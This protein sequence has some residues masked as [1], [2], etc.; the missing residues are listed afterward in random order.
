MCIPVPRALCPKPGKCVKRNLSTYEKRRIYEKRPTKKA[1]VYLSLVLLARHRKGMWKE[2]YWCM[3]RDLYMKI[4]L[5]ERRIYSFLTCSLPD[6][7]K[8]YMNKKPFYAWKENYVRKDTF[9]KDVYVH[10]YIRIYKYLHIHIHIRT[11]IY[12][13]NVCVPAPRAYSHC[14]KHLESKCK[15]LYMHM[16]VFVCCIYC[17]RRACTSKIWNICEGCA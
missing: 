5:Q 9:K 12:S 10:I 3:K 1:C 8:I 14:L 11:Y 15:K 2:T 7:R 4:D 17:E 13:K 16:H 6:T